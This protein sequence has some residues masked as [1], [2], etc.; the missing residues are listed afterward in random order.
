M[1]RLVSEAVFAKRK[2]VFV[3]LL[4]ILLPAL[5]VGYLSFNTF[6]KR[7]AAVRHLLE[8]NFLASGESALHSIEEILHEHEKNALKP[9]NFQSLSQSL[10]IS[11]NQNSQ[12]DR[13][14][15]NPQAGPTLENPQTDRAF[16]NYLYQSEAVSGK[17][18][19][20]NDRFQV[21]FPQ[22][23]N[24]IDSFLSWQE[25]FLNNPFTDSYNRAEY[26]EF[27]QK[28]YSRAA[29][30]YRQCMSLAASQNQKA[31]ALDG[32]GRSFL[33][34]RRFSAAYSAYQQL[35]SDYHQFRNKSGHPYGIA[36]ALQMSAIDR[37][38]KREEKSCEILL[39]LYEK[40]RNGAWP[41]NLT[42]YD[43]FVS[44]IE[45]S[46]DEMASQAIFPDIQ[47][48]YASIRRQP[49]L[50]QQTLRFT[51][52]LNREAV[53][54]IKEKLTLNRI[55]GE[56][57]SGRLPVNF[58][59]DFGLIS[60]NILPEFQAG[61]A[62][63]GGFLWDIEPL[64]DTLL[65]QILES[66]SLATGLQLS[67]LLEEAP[68][69]KGTG[70]F[71][72]LNV[73]VPFVS[74]STAQDTITLSFQAFPF[75]WKLR[76]T[77][78][79]FAE[80]ERAAQRENIFYGILL[81][82]IVALILF[83]AVLIVRDISRESETMR[84]KSEFVHNV[85]HEFKTPLSM[86]RLYAETLERKS[87][88]TAKQKQEAY[89]IITKESERLSHMINNVLDLSRIEMGKKEFSFEMGDLSNLVHE[90]VESYRYHLE[91]KGFTIHTDI[92]ADL[93][94]TRFDSEAMASVVINL[95]S[96][97]MKF[98]PEH[99]EVTLRLYRANG[100]AV[101]QVADKGIGIS[102]KELGRIFERFYRIT[103]KVVSETRGSGLGLPLVKHIV[104]AHGGEVR[105]E[106]EPGQGSIFSVILPLIRPENGEA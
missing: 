99:K 19:L 77:Q 10:S 24:A 94:E 100:Q 18:F 34:S 21:V 7:R 22:T 103:G 68:E 35:S 83:G 63:Y 95:L 74:A 17:L 69:T 90:T 14:L 48:A 46:L 105:V 84:L 29:E 9:D 37:R 62:F 106:S 58:T 65:P 76:V 3:F 11:L 66:V 85:S 1:M 45:S 33:S 104:E 78:P 91:K 82:V 36:A 55:A 50:Y 102:P 60:F 42:T 87:D 15:E 13:P 27:S 64:R 72:A 59:G 101:L 41:L 40:I 32:M 26:Y 25:D 16:N 2:I 12:A 23:E 93:P 73:P 6:F 80:Q 89:Q 88:L 97:A 92:T 5:I 28:E 56:A 71:R 31:I 96:N 57:P 67:L 39:D 8:S 86:I 4:A 75:P 81:A 30:L 38:L 98:S 47:K 49:A 61:K 44:E 43:F 52:A 20:L 70:T 53:P 54:K 51:D 79:A